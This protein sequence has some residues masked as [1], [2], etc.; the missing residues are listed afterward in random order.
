MF[1]TGESTTAYLSLTDKSR[2]LI[3]E[4]NLLLEGVN[5]EYIYLPDYSN[6]AVTTLREPWL[7]AFEYIRNGTVGAQCWTRS[8]LFVHYAT[9][10]FATAVW[11]RDCVNPNVPTTDSYFISCRVYYATP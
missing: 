5:I 4:L 2:V 7:N 9:S 11:G 1:E 8:I 10:G 6:L 3:N